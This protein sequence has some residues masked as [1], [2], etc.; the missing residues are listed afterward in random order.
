MNVQVQ[1]LAKNLDATLALLEERMLHPRFDQ[2]D[3]DRLKKQTIESIANQST[4]ASVVASNVYNKLLYGEGNI[5]A[6]PSIGTTASVGSI[7]LDD[8][9]KFYNDNFSASVAD[10]VVVGDTE[11]KVIMPKLAFLNKWQAKP[12]QI[13]ADAKPATIEKTKIYL[14][15]KDKAAQS[16]IRIGYMALP[17]DA[18]GEYYR[19]G[20]MNYILGGA[21]NSRINLN[22]R[23]D[24][25]YTYGAGSGFSGTESAGPYTA[26]AGV[27]TNVSDSSVV[28]F[29]KEIKRYKEEGITDAELAFMKQDFR[30]P[31]S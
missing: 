9:K 4:Q 25:G 24:K 2:A 23:E 15:N 8:V 14:V 28:E 3:F 11:Q 5:M 19:A 31:L 12:V 27:R 1:S 17:Y 21:F 6:I 18:T 10:I 22:L 16:E 30:K 13:P 20:I 29:M 7:T 26:S